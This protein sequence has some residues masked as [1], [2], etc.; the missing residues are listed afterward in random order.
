MNFRKKLNDASPGF[1]MSPMLDI[2]FIT[3]IHF[4][5]AT[6]FAKW[7]HKLEITVPTADA[8]MTT[9]RQRLELIVNIDQE[10]RIFINSIE[11]SL[12]RLRGILALTHAESA[13]LPIII[14][15]DQDTRH[16][17]VVKVLDLCAQL[18]IRNVAFSTIKP[19]TS[20]KT[21]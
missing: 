19:E 3:L 11:M 4:M 7:E 8:G 2:V 14:R 16:K 15:A 21:P 9:A 20:E 13:D 17:D 5:A 18:D 10:G 6:L 1:Q 12:K